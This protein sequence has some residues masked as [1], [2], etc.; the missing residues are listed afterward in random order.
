MALKPQ[1]E[2][3]PPPVF[4]NFNYVANVY[5][6]QNLKKHVKFLFKLQIII[7]MVLAVTVANAHTPLDINGEN[8]TPENALVIDDPTKSWTL[9]EELDEV[10]YYRL[11][12]QEGEELRVS[13][14]VSL[15]GDTN[16][17]PNLLV[18][19]EDITGRDEPP[20][21]HPEELGRVIV[22]GSRSS[23]PEYEPFTPASYYYVASYSH[24]AS[25]E[26]DY[27]IAVYS[28]DHDGQYGMAVGYR[29]TFTAWEWLKI[30]LD[31]I[32]IHLWE[33]Q[34]LILLFGPPTTAIIAGIYLGFM[35]RKQENLQT[36]LKKFAGILY[37]A[38]GTMTLTQMLVY[39]YF[40]G[41]AA[42]AL[43]TAI[44]TGTQITMGVFLLREGRKTWITLIGIGVLGIVF[45]AGW[46]I[47][48]SLVI[49]AGVFELL[50]RE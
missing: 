10:S 2:L 46:I 9:Y 16:F 34:P 30:P 29:E 14:Y 49:L 27:Y 44:F 43:L 31:L 32:R 1:T 18:M 23:H 48:P 6:L 28:L 3:T 25:V 38:S 45:W 7:L 39:L 40:S 11:H 41:V 50:R 17:T 19:G 15:W 36:I 20:F 5:R 22:M 13:L 12:L 26:G 8:S 37:F 24:V 33:E 47:G 21:P 42:S 35:Q 4:V